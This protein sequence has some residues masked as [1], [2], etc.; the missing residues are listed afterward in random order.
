M[1]FGIVYALLL[2]FTSSVGL[3][4]HIKNYKSYFLISDLFI[5]IPAYLFYLPNN[6]YWDS[7]RFSNLLDT[8]RMYNATGVL[9]G[10]KWGLNYSVYNSQ[11]LDVIYIWLFSFFN[12]N[13]IF[14]YTTIVLFLF[15]LSILILYGMKIV[16]SSLK[17]AILTQLSIL[18][19]FNI[20]FELAGIRNFL[21]FML[22]AAASYIELN[23][24][25]KK[26]KIICW[27]CYAVAYL[28]HPSV[29]IFIVF[30]I[31]LLF[32]KKSLNKLTGLFCLIY[33]LFLAGIVSIFDKIPFFYN[34]SSRIRIYL[35]GQS[36]FSTHAGENEIIFTSIILIYL[37]YELFVAYSLRITKRLNSKY[38]T[39]YHLSMLFTV[40]SFFSTQIYLR[41]IML[42]LF[43]SAP[44]KLMLFDNKLIL[45]NISS[46]NQAIELEFYKLGTFAM[47]IVLFSYWYYVYYS[48]AFVF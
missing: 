14:F 20:V 17:S 38:V 4:L 9:N 19:I 46:T 26:V 24:N 8:M 25:N 16:N 30:R 28:F 33:T 12:S 48:T 45:K 44:I 15:C 23:S 6:I 39:L 2:F 41:S 47:C 27:L 43:M 29:L 11:P 7:I 34:I 40:G 22:F 13:N 35:Y 18:M 1:N 37:I 3:V 32:N 10:L 31:I 36:G 5:A 42:L 21:A